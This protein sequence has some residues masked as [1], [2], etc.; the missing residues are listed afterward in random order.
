MTKKNH[1]IIV[2]QIYDASIQQVWDAITV[3]NNMVQWYFPNISS[4]RPVIGFKTHF[5]VEVD[6]RTF[7]HQWTLTEVIPM[8]K[9][10]YQWQFKDY[11]G[12]GVSIFEL[13]E[14]GHQSILTLTFSI[15]ENF[16]DDIPE[17][18]R[19]SGVIGWNYFIKE[20][21]KEYLEEKDPKGH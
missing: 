10:A 1:P 21:L 9:I 8:K 2:E 3:L 18:K 14:K 19:E 15:L 5:V 13:A 4:F 17:F 12:I 16:P 6:D 11:P 7:V 20:R